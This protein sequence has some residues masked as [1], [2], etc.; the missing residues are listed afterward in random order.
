M[1]D[2]H[3]LLTQEGVIFSFSGMITQEIVCTIAETVE[4]ELQDNGEKQKIVNDVFAIL[5]EQMQNVMS[6]AKD[7]IE[8]RDNVFESAGLV[9]VGYSQAKQKYFVATANGMLSADKKPLVEKLEKINSLDE[10]G[11]RSFYKEL[12]RSGQDKHGRGAGLGFLEMAKRA[13]EPLE[14]SFHPIDEAHALFE[15]KV[16]I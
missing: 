15:I 9:L 13:S 12:R 6:Y 7:R 2:L 3:N 14:Y 10:A 11:L 5:T 4:K 16:Y 8:K 1:F